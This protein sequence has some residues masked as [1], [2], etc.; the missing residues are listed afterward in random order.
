MER[1]DIPYRKNKATK[2][3]GRGGPRDMQRRH[4]IESGSISMPL[5]DPASIKEVLL[6][7]KE[8]QEELK[9]EIRK[10]LSDV[11][12]AITSNKVL[13]GVGLPFNVVE[14]KIKE[15]VEYNEK[16][17]VSR[18]ESGLASLN[19]QLNISKT[20]IRSLNDQIVEYKND[21]HLLKKE[22]SDKDMLIE[23]LRCKGDAEILDLRNTIVDLISKIK[24]GVH[25]QSTDI[26]DASKPV[27]E[28]RV[29]IDP[30]GDVD[31]GLDPHITVDVSEG[32]GDK[33]DMKSDVEK[34]KGLLGGGK[35]KKT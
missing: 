32:K 6:N 28:D 34:L 10:E 8:M 5:L 13:D 12:E 7:S 22:L 2:Q 9:D 20:Q 4:D 23:D 19:S 26:I 17:V 25:I 29:F 30:L 24:S 1:S 18:Y 14:Q 11:K 16:Q 27:I 21:I 35:F 31:V 15:A 33:R 3:L